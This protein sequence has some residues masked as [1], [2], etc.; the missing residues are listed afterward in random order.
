MEMQNPGVL[1]SGIPEPI[2]EQSILPGTS[3]TFIVEVPGMGSNLI[4]FLA[5]YDWFVV[6]IKMIPAS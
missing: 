2:F 6:D 5:A 1:F 4:G 3:K